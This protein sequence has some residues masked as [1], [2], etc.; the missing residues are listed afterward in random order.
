MGMEA[1]IL[2]IGQFKKTIAKYLD[3]ALKTAGIQR[4]TIGAD[5]DCMV[6]ILPLPSRITF[7]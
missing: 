3:Y 6:A 5:R 1:N 7:F 2:C 4:R